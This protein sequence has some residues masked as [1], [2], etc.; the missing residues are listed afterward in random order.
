MAVHDA[1]HRTVQ[2]RRVGRQS[3]QEAIERD[4]AEIRRLHEE[5]GSQIDPDETHHIGAPAEQAGDDT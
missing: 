1:I 2:G 5:A 4:A 3:H